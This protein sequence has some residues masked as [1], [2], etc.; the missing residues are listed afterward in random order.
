MHPEPE[1]G[2]GIDLFIGNPF[3]QKHE[4]VGY[5][6]YARLHGPFDRTIELF[7]ICDM[8]G[9]GLRLR[10]VRTEMSVK[11]KAQKS[12]FFNYVY[13]S[14]YD[15]ETSEWGKYSQI[16]NRN[17]RQ[18]QFHMIIEIKSIYMIDNIWYDLLR[19]TG[20]DQ[21]QE[22]VVIKNDQDIEPIFYFK[23]AYR[24]NKFLAAYKWT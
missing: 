15:D 18:Y 10:D 14:A 19:T 2:T 20:E 6:D 11:I 13:L 23:S 7:M 1:S 4:I 5:S 21:K 9:N 12:H 24:P 3:I 17:I 8:K 16:F 22:W